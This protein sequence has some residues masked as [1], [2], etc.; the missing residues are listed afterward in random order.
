MWNNPFSVF[1]VA[2]T[3]KQ[4]RRHLG[5]GLKAK[6][7]FSYMLSLKVDDMVMCPIVKKP[8]QGKIYSSYLAAVECNY[9][10]SIIITVLDC[11]TMGDQSCFNHCYIQNSIYQVFE[12]YGFRC[13][14]KSASYRS[15]S[16]VRF[17]A[18]I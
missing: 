9:H 15:L 17:S 2:G 5:H 11:N 1:N 6:S 12:R 8:F 14:A 3:Q 10:Y 13:G 16:K 4:S 7:Y 18:K